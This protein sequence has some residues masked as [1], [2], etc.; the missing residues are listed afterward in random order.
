MIVPVALAAAF[1]LGVDIRRL[2]LLAGAVYLPIAV[3]ALVVYALW[4]NR[5]GEDHRPAQFCEGVA[6]ELRAGSTLRDALTSSASSLGVDLSP[7]VRLPVSIHDLA[8]ALASKFPPIAIELRLTIVNAARSGSEVAS[9]FDEIGTLALARTE[10]EREVRVATAPGRA[11]ALLLVGAPLVYIVGQAMSGSLER[12][13]RSSQQ[14]IVAI[15]GLGLFLVG[16]AG[17]LFVVWRAGR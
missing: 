1:A 16:L 5:S 7:H 15:V 10:I 11:T 4:R 17:A 9:L 2:A 14:R 8:S 12:M 13:M 6:A 3:V